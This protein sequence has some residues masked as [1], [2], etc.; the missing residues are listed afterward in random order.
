MKIERTLHILV[1]SCVKS[2]T[3]FEKNT[4][5]ILQAFKKILWFSE[6]PNGGYP[7]KSLMGFQ[8][9]HI[10]IK[11]YVKLESAVEFEKK[12]KPPGLVKDPMALKSS[13]CH[14]RSS[15]IKTDT[16]HTLVDTYVNSVVELKK[17]KNFKNSQRGFR[18]SPKGLQ[19]TQNRNRNYFP[20]YF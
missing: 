19:T 8:T 17:K 2:T 7:Q 15:K 18:K 13:Q 16:L 10:L 20:H 6:E 1:N 12:K 5:N 14:S 3:A 11:S 9:T 4:Q